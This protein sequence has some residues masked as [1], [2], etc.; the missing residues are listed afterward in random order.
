MAP[1]LP[2]SPAR[3]IRPVVQIGGT[4]AVARQTLE[5]TAL[6][7]SLPA[8][9]ARTPEVS[10]ASQLAF[11]LPELAFHAG[12]HVRSDSPA[13]WQFKVNGFAIDEKES[14]V[15]SAEP[16]LL[17]FAGL[18]IQPAQASKR[19]AGE[20]PLAWEIVGQRTMPQSAF[21]PGLQSPEAAK[22]V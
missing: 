7:L 18:S 17:G 1:A 16:A 19:A 6:P 13:A 10:S 8:Q 2:Q 9:T 14:R 3:E 4:R 11:V 22:G 12:G 20:Q 15:A 21:R 5:T